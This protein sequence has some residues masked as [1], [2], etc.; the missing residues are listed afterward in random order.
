MLP[1]CQSS[2]IRQLLHLVTPSRSCALLTKAKEA[3]LSKRSSWAVHDPESGMRDSATPVLYAT[4]WRGRFN[5]QAAQVK[6]VLPTKDVSQ[7][8]M[9]RYKLC[10]CN[11][12]TQKDSGVA[13][14]LAGR[15]PG[16]MDPGIAS[17]TKARDEIR[18]D[19]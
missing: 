8:V 18:L 19:P 14:G 16:S 3:Y 17:R 5:G 4:K 1:R 12:R 9:G 2:S 10:A 13:G 11:H 15:L 6:Y 7:N